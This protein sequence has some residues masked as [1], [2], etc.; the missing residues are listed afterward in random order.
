MSIWFLIA[1][2]GAAGLIFY[3]LVLTFVG[4][5]GAALGSEQGKAVPRNVGPGPNQSTTT[6]P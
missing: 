2:L 6:M 4:G 1:I 5:A 3:F